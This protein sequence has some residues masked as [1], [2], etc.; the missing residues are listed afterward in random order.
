MGT[1]IGST[2]ASDYSFK[3]DGTSFD[4]TYN[5]DASAIPEPSTYAAVI[6]CA[7]LGFAMWNRCRRAHS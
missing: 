1:L 6:G 5:G 4:L 2:V 7:A 3:L